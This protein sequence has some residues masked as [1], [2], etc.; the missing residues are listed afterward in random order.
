MLELQ[1]EGRAILRTQVAIIGSGP[2]GLLLGQL[3]SRAGI[4]NVILD[5]VSKDHILSRVRAAGLYARLQDDDSALAKARSSVTRCNR[6]RD[7]RA[8]FLATALSARG[9]RISS[10]TTQRMEVRRSVRGLS[11]TS[12]FLTSAIV[13]YPAY[14]SKSG[15]PMPAVAIVIA[16]RGIK[17]RSI[18][19]SAAAGG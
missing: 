3:L 11:F 14:W 17:R 13:L 8:G 6:Q 5:R 19:I 4:D 18:R 15:R 10:P 12:G 2:S 9:T 7:H 1:S 16:M